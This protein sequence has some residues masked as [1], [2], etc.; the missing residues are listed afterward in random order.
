M[1]ALLVGYARCST[2]AQ[3]LTAQ[4]DGLVALGVTAEWVY[5][6]HGLTGT[7]RDRSGLRPGQDLFCIEIRSRKRRSMCGTKLKQRPG[8]SQLRVY[9][10]RTGR[11]LET[12][13]GKDKAPRYSPLYRVTP[14]WILSRTPTAQA[15]L[16]P[17]ELA[18]RDADVFSFATMIARAEAVGPVRV[19]SSSV[20]AG[21]GRPSCRTTWPSELARV[22]GS[23]PRSR[24]ASAPR[25]QVPP[26]ERWSLD[27][28]HHPAV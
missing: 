8:V 21:W 18:G 27:Q 14:V 16:R 2:D 28:K 19:R 25:R 7:N 20:C 17:P 15:G 24:H 9:D 12:S 4:R 11:Q 3:D 1:N 13:V 10:R 26:F 6:D 5:V 23:S 22:T